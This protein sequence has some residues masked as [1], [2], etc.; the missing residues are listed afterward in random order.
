MHCIAKR[1]CMHCR[2][3]NRALNKNKH[4][5]VRNAK[6]RMELAEVIV[7]DFYFLDLFGA[8]QTGIYVKK[9]C[10]SVI[11]SVLWD[12]HLFVRCRQLPFSKRTDI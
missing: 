3:K 8:L 2:Q 1:L 5:V 6:I 9:M 11:F 12:G 7:C 10:V 4:P